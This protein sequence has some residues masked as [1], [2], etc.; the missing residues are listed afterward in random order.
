M[1]IEERMDM[2]KKMQNMQR[3]IEELLVPITLSHLSLSAVSAESR[4]SMFSNSSSGSRLTQA[5]FDFLK[6]KMMAELKSEEEKRKLG[7]D[8]Y[9]M[10][11]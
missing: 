6:N 8:K 11:F 9:N 7:E 4:D 3:Q 5:D 2:Q 10:H 1:G